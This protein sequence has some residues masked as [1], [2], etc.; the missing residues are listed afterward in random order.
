MSFEALWNFNAVCYAVRSWIKFVLVSICWKI[1]SFDVSVSSSEQGF[2]DFLS[3]GRNSPISLCELLQ[4]I[5][6]EDKSVFKLDTEFPKEIIMPGG[7][8]WW[9][10]DIRHDTDTDM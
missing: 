1:F 5:C 6:W 8:F 2:V 10:T 4:L 7:L 3:V 9:N